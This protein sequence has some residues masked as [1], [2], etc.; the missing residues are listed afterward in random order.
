[1]IM[2]CALNNRARIT[3]QDG[4]FKNQGEPTEAALRVLAEK[5]GKFTKNT[6]NH[7]QNPNAHSD[8][9][10]KKYKNVA[11]LDFS[12][13]RKTMST[14]V[15]GEAGS[16]VVLLKGAPDR[17]LARCNG[18]VNSDDKVVNFKNDREKEEILAKINKEASQGYRILGIAIA[19]DGGKM[20]H[21]T[22]KNV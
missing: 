3:N 18:I 20:K 22:S 5:L 6:V 16:N 12:S 13:E 8:I 17:V 21:I 7:E 15:T 10:E 19:K 11:T 4:V 2:V 1:M 14:I 9:F